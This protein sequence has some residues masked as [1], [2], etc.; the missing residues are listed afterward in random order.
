MLNTLIVL[1]GNVVFAAVF[2]AIAFSFQPI[3][4]AP[5]VRVRTSESDAQWEG[6]RAQNWR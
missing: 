2:G 5:A 1:A 4:P 6:N 3:T